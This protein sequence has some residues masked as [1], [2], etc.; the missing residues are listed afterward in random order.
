MGYRWL[1]GVTGGYKE[2]Q[3]G[4]RRL[5]GFTICYKGLEEDTGG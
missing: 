1:Q 3:R 2:L 4:Y 5:Q